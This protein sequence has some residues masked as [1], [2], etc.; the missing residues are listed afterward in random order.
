MK[1]KT[2]FKQAIGRGLRLADGKVECLVLDFVGACEAHGSIDMDLG[3]QRNRINTSKAPFKTCEKCSETPAVAAKK[4]GTCATHFPAT[5][6]QKIQV[7]HAKFKTK[8]LVSETSDLETFEKW[9]VRDCEF[10]VYTFVRDGWRFNVSGSADGDG[11]FY[12]TTRDRKFDQWL[13]IEFADGQAT[14]LSRGNATEIRQQFELSMRG[15]P[16]RHHVSKSMLRSNEA[17]AKVPAGFKSRTGIEILSWVPATH[18]HVIEGIGLHMDEVARAL[19][20]Y[21][22]DRAETQQAVDAQGEID[23]R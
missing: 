14:V 21:R 15:N 12:L 3:L 7:R 10:A 19:W 9:L 18:W 17:K 5:V 4:C 20:A 6:H 22:K 1:S 2:L 11:C 16:N 13:L 23:M 8:R